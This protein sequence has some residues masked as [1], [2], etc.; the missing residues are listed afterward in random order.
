[1]SAY[2]VDMKYGRQIQTQIFVVFPGGRRKILTSNLTLQE[3]QMFL[4]TPT[5]PRKQHTKIYL[6]ETR[7][8][9]PSSSLKRERIYAVNGSGYCCWVTLCEW[10]MMGG[11]LCYYYCQLWTSLFVYIL[12]SFVRSKKE[13]MLTMSTNWEVK[14]FN[15]SIYVPIQR[16]GC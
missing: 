11:G 9:I 15:S 2:E 14:F 12:F 4:I 10:L 6:D 5:S 13:N 1:M 16:S 8:I 3:I 7:K